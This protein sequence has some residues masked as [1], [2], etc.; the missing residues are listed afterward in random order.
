MTSLALLV[1]RGDDAFLG[2]G[3]FLRREL[4][5][6]IATRHHHAI[7]GCDNFSEVIQRFGSFKLGDDQRVVR[8]SS[9]RLDLFSEQVEVLRLA[10]KR[11]GNCI[12]PFPQTELQIDFVLFRQGRQVDPYPWQVDPFVGFQDAA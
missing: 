5:A 11:D 6:E 7:G 12:H 4:D 2:D 8:A 1:G 9:V 10:D 3:Y